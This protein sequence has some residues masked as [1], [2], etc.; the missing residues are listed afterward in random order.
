MIDSRHV[1]FYWGGLLL[2]GPPQCISLGG[3]GPPDPPRESTRL[4]GNTNNAFLK[5]P[6]FSESDT[7]FCINWTFIVFVS[8]YR[9][10]VLK[11][12]NRDEARE[13][14]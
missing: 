12:R 2:F 5:C 13:D 8:L 11:L 3:S 6:F 7:I 14:G 4:G 10:D 9:Q 1:Y